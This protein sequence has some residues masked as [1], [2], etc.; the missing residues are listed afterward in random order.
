MAKKSSAQSFLVWM[1]LA[2]LIAGLGGFGID[3]FLSQRVTAIGSVGDR[4]IRAQDYSRALQSEMRAFEQQIGRP[5]TMAMAQAIG[6]DARVR[7]E[8][9]TQAALEN[10]A[11]RIG[12]SVGDANV[13]RTVA[14]YPAFNGPTGSFDMDTYRFQLQNL[15][16]TPA[17]FEET[18]RQDAARGILQAATAAGVT[19]PAAL[20]AAMVDHFA[21][22][23]AF[24]LF[25]LTEANLPAPVAA[26]TEAQVAEFHAANIARFTAPEVRRLTY[27]WITP[28]MVRAS[29]EVDD[30]SIR[31]LYDERIADYVQP[32]RRLVER[33]VFGSQVDAQAAMDRLTAGTVS[34]DALVVERGLSLEDA[35]MG[36]V[37]RA[38]L[39][40]AGD[41]VFALAE[42]GQ[43]A[44]PLM[45]ALGPALFRMNA[46][47]NAQETPFEEAR[48][49]LRD[50][51]AADRA[52]RVILEQQE[53]FDDLLAGGATLEDLANETA[54]E[55][56]TLDWSADLNEG[57]AAYSE[58][59]AAA[60]AVSADD[61][62]ELVSLSD[63]G[64]FAL[65]LDGITPPTPRP[66]AEVLDAATA[67]ARAQAV[68][69]ALMALATD[70]S[71]QLAA[72]GVDAFSEAQ[73]LAPESFEDV[74][75]LDRLPQIPAPMLE[76]LF[77]ASAGTPVIQPTD[78]GVLL[79]LVRDSQPADAGDAQ[80]Q[81]LTGAID[82]SIGSGLAQDVYGYF[83]RALQAESGITL[84]QTAIDAVHAAFP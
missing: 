63:G 17:E 41:A 46:I 81:R 43:V 55:L 19:T 23:H 7:A 6:L 45:T 53:G 61:F 82:E 56:G 76:S 59:A 22:R 5:V 33:L 8:L 44:G 32:E 75:R 74:T 26:P 24:D 28:A 72:Q 65:R 54:M 80:T 79:A 52:R 20:R 58:F 16:L 9:I 27:A 50:E 70:L 37:S 67:G 83:A 30:A 1:M 73:G 21:R 18:V 64:L 13:S 11:A 69:A 34:F 78:A 40:A 60:A 31:A 4:D 77:T 35:D 42:P 15:G 38:D 71:A 10:E 66:L 57:I 3:G 51:L 2:L 39:G 29:V 25:T 49:A 84:N 47:L 68:T 12:I 36:D 48:D 14:S 62:P